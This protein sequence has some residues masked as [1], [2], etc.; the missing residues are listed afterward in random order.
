MLLQ[1]KHSRAIGSLLAILVCSFAHGVAHAGSK[2]VIAPTR[3]VFAKGERTA[4]VNVANQGDRSATLRVLLVNKR[5]LETGLIVDVDE[6]QED[7]LPAKPMIRYSPRQVVIPAGGSQIV[8]LL[9]RRPNGGP[10]PGEYR[11][12]MVFRAVPDT[13]PASGAEGLDPTISVKAVA[14]LETAIPVIFREG[15]LSATVQF[16]PSVTR[17]QLAPG[18]TPTLTV[19]LDRTGERSVYGDL[20][21]NHIARD[22]SVHQLAFMGG[23][24]VYYPTPSRLINVGLR[25]PDGLRLNS[26][27]IHVSYRESD[28]QIGAV[29]SQMTLSLN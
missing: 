10:P 5:M 1:P 19:R 11:S 23:L 12:H 18:A 7:E 17:L 16:A 25:V 6:L 13:P 22:G 26:G 8:R 14:I 21:V 3:I 28:E 9:L 2:I 27:E 4:S 29:Q 24:A 15:E 20:E